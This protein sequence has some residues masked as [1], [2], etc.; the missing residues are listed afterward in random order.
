M[1]P[2]PIPPEPIGKMISILQDFLAANGDLSMDGSLDFTDAVVRGTE[3][4]KGDEPPMA[5]ITR[6]AVSDFPFGAGSGRMGVADYLFIV[7]CYGR[8]KITGEREAARLAGLVRAAFHN[9]LPVVMGTVAMHRIRVLSTGA[10]LRDPDEDTPFVP[11]SIGL[12]A[13]AV[14]AAS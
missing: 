2:Q 3:K 9:H 6:N 8:K 7:R 10:P 14:A 12:Y 13:S 11:V 5:I 1:M 4:E